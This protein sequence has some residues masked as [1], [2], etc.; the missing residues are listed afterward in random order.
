MLL[1]SSTCETNATSQFLPACDLRFSQISTQKYQ[2]IYR[3][4][5]VILYHLVIP[6]YLGCTDISST[7]SG[8]DLK[9][10]ILNMDAAYVLVERSPCR[11]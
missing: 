2:S 3:Y 8:V 11:T 9:N 4:L 5:S 7:M 10:A 6:V 1:F